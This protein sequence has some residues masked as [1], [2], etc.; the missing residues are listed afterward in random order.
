MG[1]SRACLRCGREFDRGPDRGGRRVC[2]VCARTRRGERSSTE[3]APTGGGTAGSAGVVAAPVRSLPAP[4]TDIGGLLVVRPLGR[5]GMGQVLL[6]RDPGLGRDVAVKMLREDLLGDPRSRRL[7]R[8]EG[9][10]LAGVH[11]PA[12]VRVYAVGEWEDWP[13]LAMEF[14]EGRSLASALEEGP[15][16]PAEALA[17]AARLAE[18]LAAVH[19]AGVV[20]GDV[21][22]GNVL[23]RA[24]DGSPCLIDFGL[25]RAPGHTTE[26]SGRIA[27]TPLYM[28]PEVLSGRRADAR[29]D[30]FSLGAV[31]FELVA[32]RPLREGLRPGALL[33]AALHEDAPL[34]GT[35]RPGVPRA[36]EA[37]VAR[38]VSRSPEFR[39]ADGGVLRAAVAATLDAMRAPAPGVVGEAPSPF[40]FPLSAP[41]GEDETVPLLGRGTEYRRATAALDDALA[42]RG[43]T[44]LVEG[45]A[46]SGKSRLLAEVE[47]AATARGMAVL[48]CPARDAGGAAYRPVRTMFLEYARGRGA[49]APGDLLQRALGGGPRAATLAPALRWFLE[50]SAGAAA[51][52]RGVLAAAARSLFLEALA[53]RP[54]LVVADDAHLLDEGS[55]EVLTAA[56]EES[57]A[58]PLA[59]LLAFRPEARPRRGTPLASREPRLEAAPGVETLRLR[60]L[61]EAAVASLL[62]VRLGLDEGEAC[63]LAPGLQRK[64]GGNPLFLLESLRLLERDAADGEPAGEGATAAR[65]SRLTVPPRLLEVALRRV[66][67][68]PRP[69]REALEVV[70][71]DG[72]GLPSALVARCLDAPRAR[73]LRVLQRLQRERGLLR[74]E[75]GEYRIEHAEVREAAYGELLPELRAAYHAAAARALARAG[76]ARSEPARLGRHL[77]LAG[78]G[79]AAAPH[80]L[81]A[82]RRLLS[83][84]APREAIGVLDEALSCGSGA[85]GPDIRAARAD[86]LERSGV[87]EEARAELEDLAAGGDAAS[88]VRLAM[89]HRDRGQDRAAD[90]VLSRVVDP[91]DDE[92]RCFVR[93]VRAQVAS[94]LGRPDDAARA[95]EEAA[96][97]APRVT[98]RGRLRYWMTVLAVRWRAGRFEEARD[99][100]DRALPLAEAEGEQEQAAILQHN[101]CALLQ[102]MGRL[103]EAVVAGERA[104]ALAHVL[105][106]RMLGALTT[107][108]LVSLRLRLL[109]LEEADASLR[110][111]VASAEGL[112]HAEVRYRI[113]H[114]RCGLAQAAGRRT[115]ALEWAD[116]ALRIVPENPAHEA[117]LRRSRAVALAGLARWEDAAIEGDRS[118]RVAAAAG[119]A[120]GEEQAAAVVC[121]ALRALGRSGPERDRFA[122]PSDALTPEGAVEAALEA[123]DPASRDR[124]TATAHRLASDPLSLRE[125]RRRLEA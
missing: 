26:S 23:L 82:G 27:G 15:V 66:A 91:P 69:E 51:P 45:G 84:H 43:R 31:L 111:A 5:G 44:V 77:R 22:P 100:L 106:V 113:A 6:A 80:L 88:L 7:F 122:G 16:P 73:V 110:Q 60:P 37:L 17:L 2:P 98:A 65:L 55:L 9:R 19:A 25:A 39:P 53:D 102:A 124:W 93:C 71:V 59:I 120:A 38:L 112:A 18:A 123:A 36:L 41:R 119:D 74:E 78:D 85:L 76:A 115:E 118:R 83:C 90:E 29:S 114:A 49:R 63:R 34:L 125:V 67:A 42:G 104:A 1:A 61:S 35:V 50:E 52:P 94:R 103:E 109:R 32:G 92:T 96:A 121:R 64:S 99:A 97:L 105:G 95:L 46:G 48:R 79:D 13:Y 86:A 108:E 21:T 10:A 8:R 75:G 33:R 30:V 58:W 28:A 81:E 101:R 20:H 107:L 54:A 57:A 116:E 89:F 68:L 70:S 72:A 4:G 47:R 87:L 117:A 14:I 24:A 62:H 11:S 40:P 12:V 3:G 56:A